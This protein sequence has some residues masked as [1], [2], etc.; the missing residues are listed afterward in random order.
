MLRLI[1]KWLIGFIVS[2][3]ALGYVS[4][5]VPLERVTVLLVKASPSSILAAL[6]LILLVAA[7]RAWRW[8]LIVGW[9]GIV[10]TFRRSFDLVQLGNFITQCVPGTIG[11]DIVR[12]WAAPRMACP[13]KEA[14]YAI[15]VDR[16]FGL[17][18]LVIVG[19]GAGF[20]FLESF[21]SDTSWRLP[22]GALILGVVCAVFFMISGILILFSRRVRNKV[23]WLKAA[24]CYA[25]R[26]VWLR[27][28][29]VGLLL[30]ISVL[31]HIVFCIMTFVLAYGLG[32]RNI[33]FF[34]LIAVLP[35]IMLITMMPISLAGWGVREG[36]MMFALDFIGI[37][38]NEALAI[39][40]LIGIMTFVGSL[41]G[42][43]VL[44]YLFALSPAVSKQS[45]DSKVG[46]DGN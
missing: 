10:V 13:L 35:P 42:A 41:Y 27:K 2:F 39:S 25:F 24:L 34:T 38:R 4:S 17:V 37:P 11:G 30:A 44:S 28:W 12:A 22:E 7:L 16:I 32:T 33:A 6:G 18:A 5:A 3:A 1:G 9:F 19:A 46:L 36:A 31:S 15:V 29:N 43:F 26:V 21:R 14:T 23:R 20:F 40:I 8:Q 45:G